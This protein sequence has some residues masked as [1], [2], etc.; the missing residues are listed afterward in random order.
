MGDA[1]KAAICNAFQ[2][3][4]GTTANDLRLRG[5]IVQA[6]YG[7]RYGPADIIALVNDVL[8]AHETVVAGLLWTLADKAPA[9]DLPALLDRIDPPSMDVAGFTRGSSEGASFYARILVRA[10]R[11][12][13][14]FDPARALGWL[15]KRAV[16]KGGFGGSRARDLRAAMRDAPDHLRALAEHFFRTVPID[17]NRWLAYHRFREAILS[18]LNADT[19]VDIVVNEMD[20]AE[21]GSDRRLFLYDAGFSLSYQAEARHGA[22]VFDDLYARADQEASLVETRVAATISNLPPS[23]FAGRA[24]RNVR[25]EDSRERQRQEFDEDIELI[26]AG[27]HLG[28]LSH[29]AR[30]YFALYSDVDREHP[31]RARIAAWLGEERTDAALEALAA[32]PSRND[33]PSFADVWR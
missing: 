20:A 17:A 10:W 4:F 29:L 8:R 5:E 16:F 26:R 32:A 23:Y 19:L 2:T 31:P 13:D 11:E 27:A 21:P 12:L 28:W 7:D 25:A 1:G 30:I 15:R 33:L 9:S 18:E 3:Q 24:G 14:A 6:Y 22:A